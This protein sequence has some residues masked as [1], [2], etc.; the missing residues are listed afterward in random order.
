[1]LTAYTNTT[2][3][4]PGAALALPRRAWYALCST[5]LKDIPGIAEVRMKG[6]LRR[7]RGI[8]G[9]GLTWGVAG[10]L[11][12]MAIELTHRIWPNPLGGMMDMWPVALGL[13]G[14]LG[15]IAFATVLGVVARSRRF[16]EL[17]LSKFAALGGLGGLM[18]GLLPAALDI[19]GLVPAGFA[20]WPVTPTLVVPFTL[21]GAIVAS[22]TLALARLTEDREVLQAGEGV[23]DIGLTTEEARELLGDSS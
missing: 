16:D 22:G 15:G 18:V 1:L 8:L 21:G 3:P 20:L 14:F 4:E 6:W 2:L 11:A 10:S 12:G 19:L 7:I 5:K 23:A 17:S 13:P 9:M